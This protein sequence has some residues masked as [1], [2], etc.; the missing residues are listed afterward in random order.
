MHLDETILQSRTTLT[1]VEYIDELM[2]FL[3]E[4][5]VNINMGLVRKYHHIKR[6]SEKAK[7]KRTRSLEYISATTKGEIDE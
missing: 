7:T 1:I 2:D 5:N 3:E 4:E 6:L